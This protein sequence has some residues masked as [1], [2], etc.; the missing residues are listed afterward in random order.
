MFKLC[1]YWLFTDCFL[2]LLLQACSW[3]AAG[4]RLLRSGGDGRG[5]GSRQRETKPCHQGRRQNVE[6][7]VNCSFK[8]VLHCF[9]LNRPVKIWIFGSLRSWKH[10]NRDKTILP[11]LQWCSC[12][13]SWFKS[14]VCLVELME[15]KLVILYKTNKNNTVIHLKYGIILSIYCM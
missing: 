11:F 2:C 6:M 13:V 3:E 5:A 12:F 1:C 10:D 9:F 8:K 7:W 14:L 15:V 4:W